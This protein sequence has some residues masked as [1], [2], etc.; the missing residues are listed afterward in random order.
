MYVLY[1]YV[2]SRKYLFP[3]AKIRI[4]CLTDN[5]RRRDFSVFACF[6]SFLRHGEFY[7]Y[8]FCRS[9]NIIKNEY[10][11]E[12]VFCGRSGCIGHCL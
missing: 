12:N 6:F 2:S 7:L 4:L 10:D 9:S 11:I 1:D 8:Y 5:I 3:T